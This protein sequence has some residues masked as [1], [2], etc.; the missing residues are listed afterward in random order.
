MDLDELRYVGRQPVDAEDDV[1]L[2]LRFQIGGQTIDAVVPEAAA[3]VWRQTHPDGGDDDLEAW[4]RRV[5]QPA[6][7]NRL[8]SGS[9]D[10]SDVV[11]DRDVGGSGNAQHEPPERSHEPVQRREQPV[12]DR[13]GAETPAG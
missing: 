3:T 12:S 7:R 9:L 5:A 8:Q 6:I 2:R 11:I 10:F 13:A 4:A 1:A